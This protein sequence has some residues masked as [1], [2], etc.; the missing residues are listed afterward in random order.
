MLNTHHIRPILAPQ[1]SLA[2][3]PS[4]AIIIIQP[5]LENQT[6]H[7]IKKCFWADQTIVWCVDVL[8]ML[9]M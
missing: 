6:M 3:R 7:H 4:P 9:N 1:K 5:S 2:H 8:A